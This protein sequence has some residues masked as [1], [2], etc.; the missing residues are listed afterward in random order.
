MTLRFTHKL[1][2]FFFYVYHELKKYIATQFSSSFTMCFLNIISISYKPFLAWNSSRVIFYFS[3]YQPYSFHS[4]I[5]SISKTRNYFYHHTKPRFVRLI[6]SYIFR[7]RCEAH[8]KF[9]DISKITNW[10][11][12]KMLPLLFQL[13]WRRSQFFLEQDAKRKSAVGKGRGL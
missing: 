12:L 10:L 8:Y 5:V 11:P 6:T 3:I 9:P 2:V 13:D 1:Y 4:A 7:T